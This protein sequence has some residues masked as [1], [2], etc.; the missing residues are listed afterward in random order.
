[1]SRDNYYN[2]KDYINRKIRH[3]LLRLNPLELR[4]LLLEPE[5]PNM[6]KKKRRSP[7][8]MKMSSSP[9]WQNPSSELQSES[10]WSSFQS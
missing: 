10:S 5:S 2:I 6:L 3:Y 9:Q 4:L 1:M 7:R 8:S